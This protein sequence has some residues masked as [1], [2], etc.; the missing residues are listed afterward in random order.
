VV[1]RTVVL[2]LA[3]VLSLLAVMGSAGCGSAGAPQSS[4]I[5]RKV[6]DVDPLGSFAFSSPSAGWSVVED[7]G[8]LRTADGGR[9]WQPCTG[10]IVGTPGTGIGALPASVDRL[11]FPAQVR[12]LGREVLLTY[13]A[14]SRMMGA[15]APEPTTSGIL[16]SSDSGATW[17]R[18]LSLAPTRDSV[19]FLA[20]TDA[21]HLWALCGS[22]SPSQPTR[23][24]LLRTIDGGSRWS[25]LPKA[26]VGYAGLASGLAPFT[27]TDIRHGWS[28]FVPSSDAAM[29]AVHTTRDGGLSWRQANE[30]KGKLWQGNGR[31]ALDRHQAWIAGGYLSESAGPSGGALYRT[32]DSGGR[33]ERIKGLDATAYEAVFF[34]DARHGW[35]VYARSQQGGGIMATSDGGTTWRRELT[36][37]GTWWETPSWVFQLVGDTLLVGSSEGGGL[38]SCR[39]TPGA[40]H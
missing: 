15:P 5:W 35:V 39:V 18:I 6:S 17:R 20:A 16:V 25:L 36:A 30:P 24:Y 14:Q 1:H 12:T 40:L 38:W 8:L 37:S 26:A 11:A 27:M 31:F 29:E 34:A 7:R 10:R 22:G 33:W 3:V 4:S 2:V 13:Y 9:D 28:W 32:S 23:T 21:K 19:L